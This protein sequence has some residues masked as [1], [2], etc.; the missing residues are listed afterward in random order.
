[1]LSKRVIKSA[2]TIRIASTHRS[3]SS[4]NESEKCFIRLDKSFN[5]T[6]Q[7]FKCKTN[8]DLLRSLVVF[9]LCSN[10]FLVQNND[11]ILH[12]VRKLLGQKLFEKVLRG[13]FYGHFVAGATRSEVRSV[14]DKMK[15]Y[16]VQSL[17]GKNIE[18]DLSYIEDKNAKKKA[19]KPIAEMEKESDK[20]AAIL[21]D[22]LDD[23]SEVSYGDGFT[24][25][26]LTALGRPELLLK[27]SDFINE[28]RGLFKVLTDTKTNSLVGKT[29]NYDDFLGKIQNK[30]DHGKAKDLF[31]LVDKD[32]DQ[33]VDLHD[34]DELI[35]LQLE[36]NPVLNTKQGDK[37]LTHVLTKDEIKEF[38]N[39]KQRIEH[40]AN[41]ANRKQVRVIID[42]EQ[43]YF[44]PAISRFATDLMEKYNKG[45]AQILNTYQAYLKNTYNWKRAAQFG[46]ED[47]VNP[48][49]EATTD[50]Y[51]RCLL[52]ILDE[53]DNRG[54]EHVSLL[55]AGHNEDTVRFAV[56]QLKDRGIDPNSRNVCFGQLYGMCD[57][58]TFCLGQAGYRV[59]KY[60]P[61]GP[62]DEV[63]PYLSRR[64]VENGA[65]FEK[66]S[67]ERGLLWKELKRR[68][69]QG[70]N[71]SGAVPNIV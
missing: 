11:K 36:L 30:I 14:V 59:Y 63:I 46:Y 39:M 45:R 55:I 70:G 49:Y 3:A 66:L 27:L 62:V 16:N 43:T 38:S 10:N 47:P 31:Q 26:K 17:I 19:P 35:N 54:A 32:G 15:D 6:E 21:C 22:S 8:A 69:T 25:I 42:A 2:S 29:L 7:A 40:I 44:Q 20:N 33:V 28:Y 58:I 71:S 56:Q 48:T 9:Q 64:A 53:L 65:I 60:I 57:H 23:V 12:I 34:W 5:N 50:S 41:H 52:R 51:H 4:T 67:K 1:M 24:A 61:Y 68:F 37:L 18:A 13:T